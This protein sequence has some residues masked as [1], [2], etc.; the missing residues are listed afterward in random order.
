MSGWSCRVIEPRQ[1]PSK[2]R[3]VISGLL[4]LLCRIDASTA[5]HKKMCPASTAPNPQFGALYHLL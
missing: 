4:A 2:E 5:T 1:S 3:Q